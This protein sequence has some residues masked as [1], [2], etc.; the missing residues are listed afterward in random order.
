MYR[1]ILQYYQ[2]DR[3]QF[4]FGTGFAFTVL[5]SKNL[6]QYPFHIDTCQTQAEW[7]HR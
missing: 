2:L 5:H 3:L 7:I 4:Y 6:V 1:K